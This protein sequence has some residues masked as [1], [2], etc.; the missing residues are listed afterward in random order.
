MKKRVVSGLAVASVALLGLTACSSSST[1]STSSASGAS[2]SA[3]SSATSDAT[4]PSVANVIN[5]AL[6]DQGFFDDAARGIAAL[7]AAG[8]KTLNIQADANNPAQWKANLESASD[9]KWDI[10]ITGTSQM[11]DILNAVA[12]QYPKQKYVIY[13]SVVDQPNVASIVYKQNEGSFLAGVLAAEVT[14]NASEFP[15]AGGTKKVGL[16]G[17]MDIPVINDFVDGFKSGVAAVDPS[18]DVLVS[19]V[20]NFTDSN[21]GFDQATA[22]YK[23]GAD[24]VFQVAGGAGIGVLKAASE[25]KKYAIGVDSNQ[26]ALDPGYVLASMEK[27]IGVSLEAAVN[28]FAAGKLEF[29]KT[30]YYGLSND[31]VKLD[32]ANNNDIVPQKIQDDIKA[33]AQKVID[34]QITVPTAL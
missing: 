27:N 30:T 23:Q 17:G 6:G 18:I 29:G 10:V 5:G 9:G 14:T 8:S 7:A 2:S 4:H 21:K 31:G 13:D 20:G 3:S 19:Y 25:S 34:G 1:P 32:F 24:V 33:Y 16:V 26:N 11:V 22:M 15:L 12:P 28:D